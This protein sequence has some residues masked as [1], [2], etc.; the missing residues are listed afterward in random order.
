MP[1]FSPQAQRAG[2]TISSRLA[3]LLIVIGVAAATGTANSAP[4]GF[5]LIPTPGIIGPIP[6]EDFSSPT[7]NYTF[8]ATDIA[9]A[10]HGYVEEEFYMKGMANAYNAPANTPATP[11]STLANVVT[12]NIP[13]T[14]R[15]VVRR[16]IDPAKFN[17]TV[18]VEWFNVTDN[19]DGEYFWVQAQQDIVRQGYAYIGVS[20]QN[21]GISNATL[22][23]KAFSPTRYNVLNVNASRREVAAPRT[24]F[25]TTS[26]RRPPRRRTRLRR[27]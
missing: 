18:L 9:L 26:S 3:A 20:A 1:A 11:P 7:N 24:G 21:N 23:L 25:R 14:T 2:R 27:C 6:S 22:G 16:P 12:P 8:F 19:F 17:G 4:P 5:N 15:I 10:S 13:Y